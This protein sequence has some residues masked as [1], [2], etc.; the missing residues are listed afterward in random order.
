MT[1]CANVERWQ[2]IPGYGGRYQASDLGRIR[3]VDHHVRV[4][5]GATRLMRGRV[6]R[7]A[8]SRR[9]P[10]LYVT[11]GHGASGSPVHYLVA[12]TFLGPRTENILDV[13]R[14]GRAWRKLTAAQALE[15]RRRLISGERG[16]DLAREYGVTPSSISAIKTGR[17]YGWLKE[18]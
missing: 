8:G 2:D 18:D 13:Y 17:Y 3:S 11:L 4:G 6:L 12:L 14:V 16:A 10:H 5:H 9:D 15:I 7:P 1:S